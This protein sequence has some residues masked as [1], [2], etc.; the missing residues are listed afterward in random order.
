MCIAIDRVNDPFTTP[1]IN[2]ARRTGHAIDKRIPQ[3]DLWSSWDSA[4]STA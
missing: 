2:H 4:T 3:A 1:T